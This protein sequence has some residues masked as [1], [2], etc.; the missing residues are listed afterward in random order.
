[1]S[2]LQNHPFDKKRIR[3]DFDEVAA[4]YDRAAVLVYEVGQRMLERLDFIRINPHTLLDLG[5]GT[6]KITHLLEKRYRDT[7][8]FTTD[9]ADAMLKKAKRHA[10]WFSKQCF[11]CTDAESL[12]FAE[13]SFDFIFSNIALPW[14]H[15]LEIALQE[16]YRVLRPDGLFMFSLFGPDTLSELQACWGQATTHFPDIR[17]IGDSLVRTKFLDPVLD[18]EKFLLTYASFDQLIQE[19]HHRGE[20]S[21][22][23][24]QATA[25]NMQQ[26]QTLATTYEIYRN[27]QNTLPV[28]YEIICGHAWKASSNKK[29]SASQQET[30]IPISRIAR[31]PQEEF[32]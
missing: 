23:I 30:L 32:A 1:M 7:N 28:T 8:I 26:L 27:Q 18:V 19:I 22:V 25:L 21:L 15:N 4:D 31:R 5:A 29:V 6:G 13:H 12:P 2:T 3:Q 17:D 11:I 9:I 14:C 10:R 16:I 24:T 20:Q